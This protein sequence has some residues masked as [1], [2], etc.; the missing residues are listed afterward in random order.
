M[1]KT[2]ISPSAEVTRVVCDVIMTADSQRIRI[3]MD[4]EGGSEQLAGAK[5]G[6]WGDIW[7]K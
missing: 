5:R 4:S 3:D 2:Y 6:Q 1:K 7:N